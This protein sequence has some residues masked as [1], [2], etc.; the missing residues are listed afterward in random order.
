MQFAYWPDN[1]YCLL[2]EFDYEA[3]WSWKSGD[4][5]VVPTEE[6]A[7]LLGTTVSELM[8]DYA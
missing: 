8:E 7:R 3:D 5:C 1:T 2:D 4:Y 6:L